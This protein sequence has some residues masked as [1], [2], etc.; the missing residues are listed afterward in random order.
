M[1]VNGKES[2]VVKVY[3]K[4]K[5]VLATLYRAE[6][7]DFPDGYMYTYEGHMCAGSLGKSDKKRALEVMKIRVDRGDFNY[8]DSMFSVSMNSGVRTV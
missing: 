1:N 2:E 4:G 6:M 7:P 5:K 8:N 3:R